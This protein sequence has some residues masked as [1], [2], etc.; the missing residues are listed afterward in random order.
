[1]QLV[2]MLSVINDCSENVSFILREEHI[3]GV[4]K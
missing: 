4:R 2:I 3:D 1:M